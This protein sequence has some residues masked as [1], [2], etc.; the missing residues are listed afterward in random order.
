MTYNLGQDKKKMSPTSA[1]EINDKF[2][3][4]PN[5]PLNAP[6]FSNIEMGRAGEYHGLNFSFQFSNIVA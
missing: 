6:F 3:L 4:K 1:P 5:I 2:V